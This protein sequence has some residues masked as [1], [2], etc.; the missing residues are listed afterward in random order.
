M[1]RGRKLSRVELFHDLDSHAAGRARN[2][3]EPRLFGVWRSNPWLLSLTISMTCLRVT[4]PTFSLLGTL[5]P[6]AMPAAF[7]SRTEAGGDL[8]MKVKDLSG[9]R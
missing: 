1:P 6:E 7:L 8:V 9:R 4:L 3:P 2:D 5:E